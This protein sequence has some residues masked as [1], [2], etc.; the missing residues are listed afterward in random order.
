MGDWTNSVDFENKTQEKECGMYPETVKYR[1]EGA[2]HE[3]S[4]FCDAGA[5]D[6]LKASTT[7]STSPPRN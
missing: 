5:V 6:S 2:Q 4:E 1:Q 7:P 3:D